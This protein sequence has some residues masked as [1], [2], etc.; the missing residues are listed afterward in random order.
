MR[1]LKAESL[2]LADGLGIECGW[3][4]DRERKSNLVVGLCNWVIGG[5]TG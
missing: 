2:R 4:E 5:N 1:I 3:R